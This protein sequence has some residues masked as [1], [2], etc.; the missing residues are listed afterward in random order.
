[1]KA[2]RK[3]RFPVAPLSERTL[4]GVTFASKREALRYSH[5]KLYRM[6]GE[7]RDLVLQPAWS[8]EINGK[9]ICE[10]TADFAYTV[11][12][13]GERVY[14]DMKSS[15]TAR[16]PYYRLRKKIVEAI[17]GVSI[18]EVTSC[19]ADIAKK[20]ISVRVARGKSGTKPPRKPRLRSARSK[21]AGFRRLTS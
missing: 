11:T 1:V 13:T 18:I 12:A 14:E 5:L 2:A 16:D 9:H 10:Y 6:A 17:H 21:N 8:A 20:P 4:D 15:G 19:R 3:G 7:I